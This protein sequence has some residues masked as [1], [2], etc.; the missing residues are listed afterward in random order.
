MSEII[1]CDGCGKHSPD[2]N[3]L[4][5]ANSWVD[6]AFNDGI[7]TSFSFSSG[8]VKKVHKI[9]VCRE[10]LGI[11]EERSGINEFAQKIIM[12]LKNKLLPK[13]D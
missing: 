11:S 10:C 1:V 3:G 7:D 6:I 13:H 4:F 8:W 9:K 5:I 12:F 2:E